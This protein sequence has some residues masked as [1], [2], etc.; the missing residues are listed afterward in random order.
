MDGCFFAMMHTH[1]YP[2]TASLVCKFCTSAAMP[3]KADEQI[4]HMCA[5]AMRLDKTRNNQ[6]CEEPQVNT[7]LP[8]ANIKTTLAWHC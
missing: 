3:Q 4:E 1:S 8:H 2:A 6:L 7:Q 5:T